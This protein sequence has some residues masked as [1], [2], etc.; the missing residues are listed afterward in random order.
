MRV[1]EIGAAQDGV[2][3]VLDELRL[4]LLDD[5]DGALAGAE[6]RHLVGDQGIAR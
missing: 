4:A 1:L 3:L 6:L 2:E 5:E